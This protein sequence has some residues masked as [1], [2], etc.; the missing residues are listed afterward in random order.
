MMQEAEVDNTD[1]G[2]H[3]GG[4]EVLSEVEQAWY[5][6]IVQD[7]EDVTHFWQQFGFTKRSMRNQLKQLSRETVP[8]RDTNSKHILQDFN[9][10]YDIIYESIFAAFGFSSSNSRI[11]EMLHSFVRQCY[12]SQVPAEFLQSKLRYLMNLEYKMRKLIPVR[13]RGSLSR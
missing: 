3:K 8:E 5:D 1:W 12:D 6:I 10:T 13:D 2:R 11:V 4:R 7:A 9:S